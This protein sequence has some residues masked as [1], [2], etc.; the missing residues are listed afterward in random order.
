MAVTEKFHPDYSPVY[1]DCGTIVV[2]ARCKPTR[3]DAIKAADYQLPDG[4]WPHG[5]D[6]FPSCPKC[7]VGAGGALRWPDE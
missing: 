6:P 5:G 4:S 3:G 7:G 1:H 2:Y